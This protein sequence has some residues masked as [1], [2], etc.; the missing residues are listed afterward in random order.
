MRRH[1]STCSKQ[2]CKYCPGSIRSH[3][4][5]LSHKSLTLEHGCV[6]I[7][8]LLC[9]RGWQGEYCSGY[10]GYASFEIC[11]D[12]ISS[13][14]YGHLSVNQ[15]LTSTLSQA[16]L[17]D[18][19]DDKKEWRSLF[20][21][22]LSCDHPWTSHRSVI[23]LFTFTHVQVLVDFDF[24]RSLSSILSSSFLDFKDSNMKKEVELNLSSSR[25]LIYTWSKGTIRNIYFIP[26]LKLI[27]PMS[28]YPKFIICW[29]A[30]L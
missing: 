26:A 1:P 16:C 24:F 7:P 13:S 23:S 20:W 15:A 2:R 19:V 5:L 14:P 25:V 18:K 30:L 22:Y 8:A 11:E 4:L 17:D 6:V 3:Y 21:G 12:F 10:S 27:W 9:L 29:T 28:W